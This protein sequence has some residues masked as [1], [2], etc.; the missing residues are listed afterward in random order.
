[1]SKIIDKEKIIKEKIAKKIKEIR[2]RLGLTQKQL[3]SKLGIADHGDN[4]GRTVQRWESGL[5]IPS[6]KTL[7]KMKTV[8]NVSYDDILKDYE[9]YIKNH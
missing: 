6:L 1:M 8:L 5:H 3:E 2:L 4:H 9:E 7:V